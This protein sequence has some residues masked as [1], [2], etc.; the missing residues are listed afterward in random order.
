MLHSREGCAAV[1]PNMGSSYFQPA[2]GV[3]NPRCLSLHF[4]DTADRVVVEASPK[5]TKPANTCAGSVC[6]F[7]LAWNQ[8]T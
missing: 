4:P 7:C 2:S 5:S 6:L 1:A 3:T 8:Q